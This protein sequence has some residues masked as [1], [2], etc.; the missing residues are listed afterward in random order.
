[1]TINIAAATGHLG[2][3]VVEELIRQGIDPDNLIAS[4]R[5]VDKAEDLFD[6]DFHIRYA[7]FEDHS[8]ML[9]AYEDTD[10]LLLITSTA[11]VE[12]R[13]QQFANALSAAQ[14]AGVR[15]IAF[16]SFIATSPESRFL[17]NPFYLYAESK[18]RLSEMTWTILRNGMY[19]DPVADWAPGLAEMGRLPYPVD[20]GKVAYISR[21]DLASATA[22]AL[23]GDDHANRVYELTGPKAVSMPELAAAL[24]EAT[25]KEILFDRVSEE[26]FARMCREDGIPD[27]MVRILLSMYEA[28]DRG[29]FERVTDHVEKLTGQAAATPESFLQKSIK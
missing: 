18:L 25:G 14:A 4:V 8:S 20:W 15:R 26:E 5:N 24:S 1:M 11:P 7:D 29:E 19:L 22:A 23:L 6:I 9:S 13:V 28:V 27:H 17:M 12:P 2:R 3:L 10:V 21:E 16:C